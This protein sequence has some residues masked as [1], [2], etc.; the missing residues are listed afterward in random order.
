MLSILFSFI[1]LFIKCSQQQLSKG[2]DMV[3][4]KTV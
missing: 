2:V 3:S 4:N 1:Y